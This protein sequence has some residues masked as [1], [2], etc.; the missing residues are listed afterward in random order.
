MNDFGSTDIRLNTDNNS[1][2]KSSRLFEKDDRELSES[3]NSGLLS[4]GQKDSPS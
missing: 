4:S 2:T 1:P 3:S